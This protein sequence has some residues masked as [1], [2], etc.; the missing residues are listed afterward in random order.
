M[1]EGG[2]GGEGKPSSPTA[3]IAALSTKAGGK[4][5][6]FYRRAAELIADAAD[7]LEHAHSV[8]IVHRD[9]KPGNLLVDG[10]GKVYVSDFGL[11]RTGPDAG[12]TMSGDLLGTLRYMAPEQAMA[13]HGL[14]D[15]RVDVYGLGCTLYELLTGRP[16]V[17]GTDKADI[18]RHIAFEEPVAMRKLDKGIP[19][20]LETVALKCLAKNPG[21]R[22]ATA[23]ELAADLRRFLTDTPIRA[24]PPSL[25]QKAAR[26]ARR[27]RAAVWSAGTA[28]AVLL[29]ATVVILSVSNRII[30]Y[31]RD[32]K[33]NA[34]KEK[35]Q[36]LAVAQA[37]YAKS[38]VERQRADKHFL[39]ARL[40]VNRLLGLMGSDAG[41]WRQV[42]DWLRTRLSKETLRFYEQFLQ[43]GSTDPELRFE[44]G[45]A[46]WTIG[47]IRKK[48]GE[49]DEAEKA[50]RQAVAMLEPLVAEYPAENRYRHHLGEARRELSVLLMDKYG[51][52]RIDEAEAICRQAVADW[53][54]LQADPDPPKGELG[55]ILNNLGTFHS[56]RGRHEEALALYRRV[57]QL[58]PAEYLAH[59]NIGETLLHL[60]QR[61]EAIA[62]I[63]RAVEL[64]PNLA[65]THCVLGHALRE[66]GQFAEALAEY[67][68]GHELG[69]KQ[70]NWTQ[71][72]AKW[73][74]EAE[75]LAAVAPRLPALLSGEAQPADAAE[76]ITAARICQEH[77]KL[78]AAAT[79]FYAA[80]F[81]AEPK[82]A[83]DVDVES[84]YSAACAAALAGCGRGEDAAH[85]SEVERARL[86]RQALDWLTADLGVWAS[87]AETAAERSE[88]R[89]EMAHWQ[90]DPDFA[91]VRGDALA[92]LPKTECLA[93]Q[94][95]WA[96]VNA[97]LKRCDE[98][99]T[100]NSPAPPKQ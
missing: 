58:N 46:A 51:D 85:V 91:G 75:Q 60:G 90:T 95:L 63:R 48:W 25:P 64:K 62:S 29:A 55:M 39:R 87:R 12:L 93:W 18:L 86:R 49:M 10:G 72:S 66:D 33:V 53:E 79:R 47:V 13:R 81:A 36:A 88:V 38:E 44:T 9:V 96:D 30:T 3:P 57:L 69:L 76:R 5:R 77:K 94:K 42:P 41:D 59:L 7:A 14:A 37:N 82:L 22:Y 31:E 83:N 20:E 27:H 68:R 40:A 21:E 45:W 11:A 15:H 89:R 26:W 84:R 43:E 35:E 71:P 28:A 56:Q 2:R 54:K 19:A 98:P 70:P 23:G 50:F 24:K 1:G 8:G 6:A 92:K 78:Y 67:R 65:V 16:A 32:E 74:R 100:K 61:Q 34:L 73:V 17:R 99:N 4:D 80:A 52:E 97:L